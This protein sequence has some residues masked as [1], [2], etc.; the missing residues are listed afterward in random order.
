M[1][2]ETAI[3]ALKDEGFIIKQECGRVQAFKHFKLI[4][5]FN[6]GGKVKGGFLSGYA[7]SD[8][9]RFNSLDEAIAY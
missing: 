9:N 6:V 2:T 3:K 1:N 4:N 8:I 5:F 7:G